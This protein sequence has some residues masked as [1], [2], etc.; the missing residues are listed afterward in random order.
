MGYNFISNFTY[1]RH[2][3]LPPQLLAS[4]TNATSTTDTSNIIPTAF[5]NTS[6]TYSN[7]AS[8]T[9]DTSSWQLYSNPETGFSIRYPSDFVVNKD[10][11][12]NLVLFIPKN[13]Y[14]HWPLL[15]DAKITIVASSSCP[16]IEP[17][18]RSPYPISVVVGTYVFT[19]S[20]GNDVGAGNI[21]REQAY[22]L[23]NG[24]ICYHVDLFDHGANGS[25]LYVS[26]Q[27]L[28]SGY[29]SHHQND[30]NNIVSIFNG[31]VYSFRLVGSAQGIPENQV[32][33]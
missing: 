25:G 16:A 24:N 9:I 22:D 27:S 28:I 15:D 10:T 13:T 20:E 3:T 1:T 31:V 21:Y 33:P 30:L 23:P 4:S 6:S 7:P 17:G 26:D 2:I 11:V 8:S 29:D 12:G 19:Y 18:V 14:F 32:S 5:G